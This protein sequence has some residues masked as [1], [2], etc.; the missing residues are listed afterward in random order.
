MK[1]IN[2]VGLQDVAAY[3]VGRAVVRHRQARRSGPGAGGGAAGP[4]ARRA[5]VRAVAGCPPVITTSSPR[6]RN[7]LGITVLIIEHDMALVSRVCDRLVVMKEGS[8]F[9]S[10][11]PTSRALRS[12]RGRVADGYG[13]RTGRFRGE[14]R[15]SV[16]ELAAIA[17]GA[18]APACIYA[19]I[20]VGFVLIYRATQIFNFAQGQFVFISALLFVT[21]DNHFGS[22]IVAGVISVAVSMVIG[23]VMYL[24]ADATAARAEH[25]HHGDGHAESRP[26]P[27]STGS[28]PSSGASTST[29]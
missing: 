4:P 2:Y 21:A 23:A 9:R 14:G 27:S 8:N 12:G 28:S 19:L 15:P 26:R 17:V 1:Y 29:R 5:C 6:I 18:V 11:R 24:G 3:E 13:G 20:A 10:G 25:L 7:E 22:L 16:N